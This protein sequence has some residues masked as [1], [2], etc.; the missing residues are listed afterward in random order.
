MHRD[1]INLHLKEALD[2]TLNAVAFQNAITGMELRAQRVEETFAEVFL[3]FCVYTKTDQPT[4]AKLE[5]QYH[6]DPVGVVMLLEMAFEK[7]LNL[8]QE[9]LHGQNLIHLMLEDD[10]FELL[11]W[12]DERFPLTDWTYQDGDRWSYLHYASYREQLNAVSF[13][14]E[15]PE[16]LAIIDEQNDAGKS[17]MHYAIEY[18]QH[19]IAKKIL[20]SGADPHQRTSEG[21]SLLHLCAFYEDK[22]FFNI[23]LEKGVDLYALNKHKSSVLQ[24]AVWSKNV[25]MAQHVMSVGLDRWDFNAKDQEGRTIFDAARL[26][27]DK[28]MLAYLEGVKVALQEK[29][30]LI[31]ATHP[32]ARPLAEGG[33]LDEMENQMRS[34]GDSQIEEPSKKPLRI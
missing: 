19:D 7:G 22:A 1:Q 27:Q 26:G 30:S 6:A 20:E 21:D 3:S 24:D 5:K 32:L 34:H 2:G 4:L 10:A 12:I 13:L 14:L 25:E 23:I 11:K 18:H 9:N 8:E 28:E 31:E 29:Q 15:K 33:H 17:A 16:V